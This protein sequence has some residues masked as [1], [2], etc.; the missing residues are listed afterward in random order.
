MILAD[1]LEANVAR[2]HNDQRVDLDFFTRLEVE[3]AIGSL[4]APP[5]AQLGAVL[6]VRGEHAVVLA[7]YASMLKGAYIAICDG[8][9]RAVATTQFVGGITT[10]FGPTDPTAVASWIVDHL[11]RLDE[12]YGD[13]VVLAAA[14]ERRPDV[15]IL[16]AILRP[17][18]VG[19]HAKRQFDP[20]H[21]VGVSG[22]RMRERTTVV[23]TGKPGEPASVKP[24]KRKPIRVILGVAKRPDP[25]AIATDSPLTDATSLETTGYRSGDPGSAP[26][27]HRAACHSDRLDADQPSNGTVAPNP[28]RGCSLGTSE[29][30]EMKRIES[31]GDP[32]QD[33]RHRGMKVVGSC[34]GHL[35]N[36]ERIERGPRKIDSADYDILGDAADVGLEMARY[37]TIASGRRRRQQR[38]DRI[39]RF[40][41]IRASCTLLSDANE[42][43]SHTSPIWTD[44]PDPGFGR[45]A[46]GGN[47]RSI[48]FRRGLAAR[49]APDRRLSSRTLLRPADGQRDR[50]L[51]AA[52][53]FLP[54]RLLRGRPGQPT[55]EMKQ[56]ANLQD[57]S[58]EAVL[59]PTEGASSCS[60][61]FLS[62]QA[63]QRSFERPRPGAEQRRVG[64][65][66]L[67]RSEVRVT[68][69]HD[70]MNEGEADL[71]LGHCGV[72][73]YQIGRRGEFA[74]QRQTQ[75]HCG[76]RIVPA[77]GTRHR[78]IGQR[79]HLRPVMRGCSDVGI[80]YHRPRD[81]DHSSVAPN[82]HRPSLGCGQRYSS[83]NEGDNLGF[84]PKSGR[85]DCAGAGRS[86]C[87]P[88]RRPEEAPC[89]HMAALARHFR[90]GTGAVEKRWSGHAGETKRASRS[91]ARALAGRGREPPETAQSLKS[92]N[93]FPVWRR[94]IVSIEAD[95]DGESHGRSTPSGL[96]LG[97]GGL[98][99]ALCSGH[100]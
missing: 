54:R 16:R 61:A 40:I 50:S 41:E 93:V 1:R 92:I 56:A 44:L 83:R 97:V 9:T 95:T 37:N 18:D 100:G 60:R 23:V 90:Q 28:L 65:V 69:L 2:Q 87:A 8:R 34:H 3:A 24:T 63:L 75:L 59:R 31:A 72:A 26:R 32:G 94:R 30:H 27:S 84:E 17:S 39:P 51:A 43:I 82:R 21:R 66:L 47:H 10:A 62:L 79:R 19:L 7:A 13:G 91:W 77:T 53:A 48:S 80:P 89:R 67:G 55:P 38:L 33:R 6:P 86:G 85:Q 46:A 45:H 88:P 42:R 98:T 4:F 68:H 15:V 36:P 74:P 22:Q 5:D 57:T 58:H 11:A 96:T 12:H 20:D 29:R 71:R 81:P 14:I 25:A 64:F 73:H 76:G 49:F 78:H 52:A 99:E 70:G 35:A